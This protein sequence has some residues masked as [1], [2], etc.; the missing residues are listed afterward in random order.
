MNSHVVD[1][2]IDWL[3]STTIYYYWY[4]TSSYLKYVTCSSKMF[5]QFCRLM[6]FRGCCKDNLPSHPYWCHSKY[7]FF[8][9]LSVSILLDCLLTFFFIS[10]LPGKQG[11][12][13]LLLPQLDHRRRWKV[14]LTSNWQQLSYRPSKLEGLEHYLGQAQAGD[15]S[16]HLFTTQARP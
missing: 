16:V 3:W 12:D 15:K 7:V 13:R 4:K 8:P 2:W 6:P 14:L 10:S 9:S 1:K 5:F 11:E